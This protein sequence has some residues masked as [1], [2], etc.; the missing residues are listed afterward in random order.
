MYGANPDLADRLGLKRQ[1][2]HAMRLEF[3]HPRTK[4][5]TKVVS[6]YPADLRRSLQIE[7]QSATGIRS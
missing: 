7:R 3:R 5:W 2:L 6:S 1:W 4:I